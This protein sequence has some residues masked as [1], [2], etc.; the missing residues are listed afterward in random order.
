MNDFFKLDPSYSTTRR[1]FKSDSLLN[2][3]LFKQDAMVEVGG[4][5]EGGLRKLGY[6]KKNSVDKPIITILTVVFNGESFLEAS[7][8][9]VINQ[10]YDNVEYII[11][12]GG[13][14]DRTLEIIYKYEHLIDYWVSESD[15]GIYDAMNKALLLASSGAWV[16][17]I[18]A[19][20]RLLDVNCLYS[21]IS[22][23]KDSRNLLFDVERIDEKSHTKR[24]HVCN[25][26]NA[27]EDF[28]RFPLHHQGF[29]FKKDEELN[30]DINLG[31]HADLYFM[32]S[33]IHRGD[34]VKIDEVISSYLTGG[35][36]SYIY[37]NNARSIY[38]VARR[39]QS[40]YY[41]EIIKKNFF[42][43]LK[44]F[45]KALVRSF[46]KRLGF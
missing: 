25:V 31:V 16:L 19:D 7:I 11:V 28:L 21:A 34:V 8:L 15:R 18:G 35:A 20:D 36:S 26:P 42:G 9:S 1:L 3:N 39:L 30:F 5:V 45:T 13:S 38:N 32:Y 17:I 2:L 23:N 24:R 4:K 44:F 12:D 46:F 14:S 43:F 37:L 33:R 41:P 40:E 10:E 27:D 22:A 6:F 29:V